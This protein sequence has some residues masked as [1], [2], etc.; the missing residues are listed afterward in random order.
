METEL[1]ELKTLLANTVDYVGILFNNVTELMIQNHALV[2]ALNH[3]ENSPQA[4]RDALK[5]EWS[6]KTQQ[7]RSQQYVPISVMISKLGQSTTHD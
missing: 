4:Y 2:E 1:S 7:L 5:D 6:F 3:S